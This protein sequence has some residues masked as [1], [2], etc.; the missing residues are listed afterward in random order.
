MYYILYGFLYL[1]SLLPFFIVYRIADCIYFLLYFVAGYRKKVV[2]ENLS[3]A[4]PNKTIEERTSIAK[5]FYKNLIDTFL[6]SIKLLSMSDTTFAKRASMDLSEVN[7]LIAKGKNLQFHSGHQM[8]WEYAHWAVATQIN[9][10]WV[11]VYKKIGNPAVDRLFMKLRSKGRTVLVA[12]HEFKGRAHTVF[13]QQYALGLIADQNAGKP[14]SGYWLNFFGRP[15]PFVTGPDKGALK[16]NPAIIF[17]K[18]VKL[19]RGYYRFEPYV[20]AEEGANFKEG[21]LTRIYR[22]FLEKSIV[23][24]PANYLWTHRRWRRQYRQEYEK[25]WIDNKPPLQQ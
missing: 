24:D 22:D 17:V 1:V 25:R 15:V 23:E 19:K 16:N 5:Q 12:V 21:E 7:Q 20:I 18:F 3:I 14:A 13:N 8:N 10:S 2:M 9:T 4:F 6:E 11:G